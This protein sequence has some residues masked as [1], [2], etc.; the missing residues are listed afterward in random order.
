MIIEE[1]IDD[2]QFEK[3]FME[4]MSRCFNKILNTQQPLPPDF[5]KVLNDNRW[6]LITSNK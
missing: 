4:S 1:D 6:D 3:P 5:Q 2:E